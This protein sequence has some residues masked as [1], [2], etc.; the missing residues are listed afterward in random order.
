MPEIRDDKA[1]ARDKPV[2]W[3]F[4]SRG[5]IAELGS[6]VKNPSTSVQD[7]SQQQSRGVRTASP[8]PNHSEK[9]S[10]A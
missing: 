6:P 9:L 5:W 1:L 7:W 8:T 4:T 2:T 10:S 3:L